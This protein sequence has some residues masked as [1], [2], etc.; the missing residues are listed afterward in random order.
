MVM[1]GLLLCICC[2][3]TLFTRADE[4]EGTGSFFFLVLEGEYDFI[5][6]VTIAVLHTTEGTDL[7]IVIVSRGCCLDCD[8]EG[9]LGCDWV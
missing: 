6:L 1:A 5:H 2:S 3:I 7:L 8:S 4:P 9:D